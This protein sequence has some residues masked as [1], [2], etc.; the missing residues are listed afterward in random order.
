MNNSQNASASNLFYLNGVDPDGHTLTPAL[1]ANQLVEMAAQEFAQVSASQQ[2]AA[3]DLKEAKSEP[4]HGFNAPLQDPAEAGWG[5]LLAPGLAAGVQAA[6]EKLVKH[7]AQRYQ[8]TP[9]IFELKQNPDYSAFLSDN[10]VSPGLGDVNLVPYYLLLV[11]SPQ[12][13]SFRFQYELAKEYAVGRLAFAD[14]ASYSAYIDQLIDYETATAVPNARQAIFWAPANPA[15][16]ATRLSSTTL[17]M[18]VHDH[19]DPALG[20]ERELYL[21]NRVDR[22]ATKLNLMQVLNRPKPPTLLFSA[23]H[24]MGFQKPDPVKQPFFQGALVE[25]GWEEGKT[26]THGLVFSG[27]DV[28]GGANVRGMVHLAFA[29]F[30]AGTPTQDDYAYGTQG[31]VQLIAQDPF[32]SDLANAELS[33]GAL[34]FVGHVDRAWGFSFVGLKGQPQTVGFD[35]FISNLLLKKRAWPIGHCLRDLYD[36]ALNLSFS[37]MEDLNQMNQGKLFDPVDIALKWKERNDARAYAL[38]GDPAARVR[39]ADIQ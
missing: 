18:P 22:A 26:L 10:G 13:I 33:G 34:G 36:R 37:L 23:S 7:R 35:R 12:Q 4:T 31:P 27:G 8:I 6:I 11:G 30:G 17:V 25:Q 15:D 19:L 9:R 14:A 32:V 24:G 20:F 29:C 16:E 3:K 38:M 2:K 5:V 1:T 21:G 39:V 28:R